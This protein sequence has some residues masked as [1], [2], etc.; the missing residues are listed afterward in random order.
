MAQQ[1]D[2][3]IRDVSQLDGASEEEERRRNIG[4]LGG[5]LFCSGAAVALLSFLSLDPH[6]PASVFVLIAIALASGIVCLALPWERISPA[7]LH[8]LPVVGTAL[9][10][11]GILGTETHG[12]LYAWLYV[13]VVVMVAYA[14]RRRPVVAAYLALVSVCSAAPL[15]DPDVSRSEM[16]RNL[17]VSVPSLLMAAAVVTYLRERL[18][19]GRDAYEQLSRL[20]PL[21]GVGNYRTLY[22]R[23]DYEIARHGRHDR[24][25]A[26]MLLDLNRF[27]D[28]NEEFGH[29]EGDRLLREVGRALS[30]TVRDQDTV[31][32]QGGD[33]FAVLAPE[34]TTTEIMTLARRLQRAFVLI[35]IGDRS[36]SASMGW[37]IYPDDG[38]T[39]ETLLACADTALLAG[40]A[41]WLPQ[42]PDSY[43]PEH[44]RQLTEQRVPPAEA[45]GA[46]A[47]S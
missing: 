36:L 29:L 2:F 28:V 34:T 32:R 26:V 47:A 16:L 17:L 6:P 23:L 11:G 15:L 45:G 19:A 31:V 41:R 38:Q 24:R 25:F 10:T 30:A 21:T 39:A 5:L 18:E 46:S 7:W 27:K 3:K 43:W 13:P 12:S 35:K 22:E 1:L 40:K 9:I 37:A 33:E 4:R 8:A 44:L 20:D 42:K 14:F